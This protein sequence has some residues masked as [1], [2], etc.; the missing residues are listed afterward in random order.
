MCSF[1]MLLN[2]EALWR[3]TL[4]FITIKHASS[5]LQNNHW[6]S[7]CTSRS[8]TWDRKLCFCCRS[9]LVRKL[10]ISPRVSSLRRVCSKTNPPSFTAAAKLEII[11]AV[12]PRTLVEQLHTARSALVR[13]PEGRLE[14]SHWLKE[15][16]ASCSSVSSFERVSGVQSVAM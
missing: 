12:F 13:F 9:G 6:G 8:F 4:I 14:G 16:P 2:F 10:T 15:I 1:Y 3:N 5:R 11:S 7:I